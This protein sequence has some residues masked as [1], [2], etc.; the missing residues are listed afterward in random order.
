M[1]F[2]KSEKSKVLRAKRD[3]VVYKV[4]CFAD[5]VRF[6]SYFMPYMY[7]RN[8]PMREC[9]DFDRD[10]IDIGLHSLLSLRGVCDSRTK[11]MFF[12]SNGNLYPFITTNILYNNVYVGKFIIPKGSTYIVNCYNE[13]V[14][15][16]L[17]YT[18]K[19]KCINKNEAFN[20]KDLWKEKQVKYLFVMVKLI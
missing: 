12:F 9:V 17:I 3:I 1:C 11:D 20:V 18:G 15:N 8:T 19:F 5:E 4:G 13:V 7:S 2:W 10:S 6:Y 14:S 16:T